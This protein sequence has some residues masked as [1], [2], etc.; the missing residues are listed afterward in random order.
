MHTSTMV[1]GKYW[2]RFGQKIMNNLLLLTKTNGYI[3]TD[4]FFG[5][6]K[7]LPC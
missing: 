4:Y 2:D 3:L 5:T 6:K 1:G 7:M